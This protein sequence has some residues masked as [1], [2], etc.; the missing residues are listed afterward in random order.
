MSSRPAFNI[1]VTMRLLLVER[2]P[3]LAERLQE[4]LES[5]GYVVDVVGSL[6]DALPDGSRAHYAAILMDF[7]EPLRS[8]T[9]AR[10]STEADKR[11]TTDRSRPH[12]EEIWFG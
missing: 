12:D 4:S 11:T 7:L 3:H 5:D 6:A 2:N 1:E 8:P 9:A 10:I